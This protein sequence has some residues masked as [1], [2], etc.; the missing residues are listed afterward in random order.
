MHEGRVNVWIGTQSVKE[1]VMYY[2]TMRTYQ[3]KISGEKDF[4]AAIHRALKTTHHRDA[5]LEIIEEFEKYKKFMSENL[6]S[7]V[8]PSDQIF[9]F[10]FVYQM[11]KNVSKDIEVYGDQPLSVLAEF[12]IGTMGWDNDHLDAFFFPEKRRD[13]VWKWYTFYEIGSD[14]ADN[15]QYPTLHTEE[16]PVACIDYRKHPKLGFAF[17]FGDDHRFVMEYKGTRVAGKKEKRSTFPKLIDQRGVP[18]EQYPGYE[19]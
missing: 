5:L 11:K 9:T 19:M 6:V 10:R 12:L 3:P 15:D 4:Y 13:G 2:S 18:P 14:G 17:D 16:V 8:M 1:K 7:A